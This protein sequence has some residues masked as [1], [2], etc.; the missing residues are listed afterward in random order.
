MDRRLRFSIL[1]RNW[2]FAFREQI[3][4]LLGISE[5]EIEQI[6][7]QDAFYQGNLGQQPK[8]ETIRVSPGSL[9]GGGIDYFR[10]GPARNEEFQFAFEDAFSHPLPNFTAPIDPKDNQF[11]SIAY[12]YMCPYSDPLGDP[13][14]QRY[15]PIGLLQRMASSSVNAIWLGALLGISSSTLSSNSSTPFTRNR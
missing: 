2:M 12:P 14:Y 6:L 9:H 1:P 5:R 15:Y 10:D 3:A 8:C 7:D 11:P 4:V 13:G